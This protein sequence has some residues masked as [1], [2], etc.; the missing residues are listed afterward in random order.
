MKNLIKI[1]SMARMGHQNVNQRHPGQRWKGTNIMHWVL[2]E[3]GQKWEKEIHD[4]N[5]QKQDREWE[6]HGS[7]QVVEN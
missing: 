6:N 2:W 3:E 5:T 4:Q 7:R 1:E